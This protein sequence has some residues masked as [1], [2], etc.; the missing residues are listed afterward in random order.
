[1]KI[2]ILD[3]TVITQEQ[4]ERLGRYGHVEIF[5]GIAD[6]YH[7]VL[8]RA[9]G[10]EVII[11][12]W[13][14]ISAEIIQALPDLRF[15]SVWATGYDN[16]DLEAATGQGIKVAH[17]PGYAASAV[18]EFTIGLIIAVLRKIFPADQNL[19]KTRQ[20]NWSLF[21]GAELRG[22]RLGLLGTGAIGARVAEIA[23]AFGSKLLAF[24]FYPKSSLAEKYNLEYLALDEVLTRSD[25]VSLHLPL[26][27]AT[28]GFISTREF[29]LMPPGAI[30]IN[31]AR[32]AIVDQ[33]A[34]LAALDSGRLSAAG[35][36]DI[37]LTLESAQKLLDLDQVIL[38]PHI[39][40]NTRE[41]ILQKTD[42]CI[43]NIIQFLQGHPMN[44]VN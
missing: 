14:R 1:M 23:S 12:S 4:A 42:I 38:T 33:A 34:L 9:R 7:E 13:T 21:Q 26:T 2:V 17:V 35:L 41:A 6:G 11:A 27:A 16:V 32:A 28:Q 40:F 20:L 24:D 18:A 44:I 19:R 22:K 15:I 25:I 39:G 29:D 37:D 36:D 8:A 3:D 5:S 10:A 43:E 31:T 30:F